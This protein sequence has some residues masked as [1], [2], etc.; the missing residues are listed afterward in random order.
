MLMRI[1]WVVLVLGGL[2]R[3]GC[4]W[5]RLRRRFV[6]RL[7]P[8]VM[9]RLGCPWMRLRRRFV[10]RL[11]PWVVGRLGLPRAGCLR[12]R[13]LGPRVVLRLVLLS[14]WGGRLRLRLLS[15]WGGRLRLRLLSPW[16]VG[17][18]VLLLLSPW[19]GL[20]LILLMLPR[21]LSFNR[22]GGAGENCK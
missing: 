17:R 20:G 13:L 1:P 15:P 2:M 5:M 12:L 7:S 19:V 9:G 22:G 10:L 14:P 11:S 21:V 8:W 4:P 3:L 16:V 18:G 6:L